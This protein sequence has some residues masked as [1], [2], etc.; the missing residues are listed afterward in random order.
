MRLGVNSSQF[1]R[2]LLGFTAVFLPAS[3]T[4]CLHGSPCQASTEPLKQHK[5]FNSAHL[6]ELVQIWPLRALKVWVRAHLF[7]QTSSPPLTSEIFPSACWWKIPSKVIYIQMFGLHLWE[8][9]SPSIRNN[10]ERL[11]WKAL[12][13]GTLT[14]WV[15]KN[16]CSYC[17]VFSKNTRSYLQ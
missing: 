15:I 3:M 16:S 13:K 2:K 6:A 10:T 1:C 7:L 12:G 8:L 17:S 5:A 11:F 14:L 9:V 4:S